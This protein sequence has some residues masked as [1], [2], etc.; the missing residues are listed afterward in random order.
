MTSC[1]RKVLFCFA[2]IRRGGVTPP[3]HK[4]QCTTELPRFILIRR[5]LHT[6]GIEIGY[7]A[8]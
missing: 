6:L 5:V 3:Y 1:R 4:P 8:V 2:A 7:H